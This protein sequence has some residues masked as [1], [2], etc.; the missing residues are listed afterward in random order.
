LRRAVR[1]PEAETLFR[2]ALKVLD[3]PGAEP[4]CS[5]A[6]VQVGGRC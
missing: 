3:V 6:T 4:S 2:E 1:L 5:L